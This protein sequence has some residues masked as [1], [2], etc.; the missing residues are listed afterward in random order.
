M[1]QG[2]LSGGSDPNLRLKGY[3]GKGQK[4]F[5]VWMGSHGAEDIVLVRMNRF[6]M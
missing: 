4:Q 6:V 3:A 1:G 2:G 5:R